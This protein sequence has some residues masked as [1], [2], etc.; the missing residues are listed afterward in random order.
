MHV[1]VTCLPPTRTSPT[2]VGV[3]L[4]TCEGAF[5]S[6]RVVD[7]VA[8]ALVARHY[9]L[10]CED[11]PLARTPP[12]P[13]QRYSPFQDSL[14]YKG[15]SS[16]RDEFGRRLSDEPTSPR[17]P[18]SPNTASSRGKSRY[19]TKDWVRLVGLPFG[20]SEASVADFFA[21]FALGSA[22][23]IYLVVSSGK[24][25]GRAF[26]QLESEE[27]SARAARELNKR[28]IGR[29][30]I[31]VRQV[32]MCGRC[33]CGGYERC[34]SVGVKRVHFTHGIARAL[35]SPLPTPTYLLSGCTP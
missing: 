3:H 25:T 18:L 8:S 31:D 13:L 29:R 6:L 35:T 27:E 34:W 32:W 28:Y 1:R 26:V 22:D 21:G 33:M 24:P 5:A 15:L 17:S 23:A 19:S 11:T 16:M 4:L 2:C 14:T 20:A 7:C 9:P 12:L 30:Y 10:L